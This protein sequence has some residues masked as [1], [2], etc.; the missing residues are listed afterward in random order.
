L[1][2]FIS[3]LRQHNCTYVWI[4]KPQQGIWTLIGIP[5]GLQTQR[6]RN[7]NSAPGSCG[8]IAVLHSLLTG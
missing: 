2:I 4:S 8:G 1:K 7:K 6:L 5:T 3:L